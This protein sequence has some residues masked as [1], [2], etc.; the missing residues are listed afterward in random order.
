MWW[1]TPVI[2]ATWKADIWRIEVWGQPFVNKN[3]ARDMEL[4]VMLDDKRPSR[5]AD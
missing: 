5:E 1:L 4:Q 2:L 3:R